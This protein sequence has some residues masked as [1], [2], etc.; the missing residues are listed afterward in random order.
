[1]CPL[2]QICPGCSYQHITYTEEIALKQR[3]CQE[4]LNR[5]GGDST[6]DFLPPISSPQALGYRNK[7]TLHVSKARHQSALGYISHDNK[8]V[9]DVPHCPLAVEPIND[10]LSEL[11]QTSRRINR[12]TSGTKVTFRFT[13]NDGAHYYHKR[14]K[15]SKSHLVESTVLGN[16]RVPINSFFQVNKEIADQL[17]MR[18]QEIL[19]QE[20][21]KQV[22]DLYCGVGTFSM[23]AIR[24]G[25]NEIIGMD[26]DT[27]AIQAARENA[28]NQG[29][30]QGVFI[31]KSASVGMKERLSEMKSSPYLLILDPPRR[32]M[33]KEVIQ[34]IST[35]PPT[36]IL[37]I[38]CAPDI[39]A[40]DL[41]RLSDLGFKAESTQ[42]FD[43]FPR[44]PY[45]ETLTT[46]RRT[47][48]NL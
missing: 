32:G 25:V 5:W 42:L 3:Q 30:C 1:M 17:I 2:Y 19:E 29:Y 9:F 39:L 12:L 43:M 41:S 23:A 14:I 16:I 10:L 13:E 36:Q 46:L 44:T 21:P 24:A 47:I 37:Y 27:M 20:R 18:V 35:N 15:H 40:R 33:D 38:S 34:A 48:G 26:A 4:L 28:E 45:T 31:A 8:T 6:V 11:R 22:I 7:I